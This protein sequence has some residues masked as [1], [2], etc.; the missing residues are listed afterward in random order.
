MKQFFA[1]FLFFVFFSSAIAQMTVDSSATGLQLAQYLAG[2]GVNISN[3][4]M[5]CP[6]GAFA[7][8]DG[9]SAT[10]LGIN[11]GVALT[12]GTALALPQQSTF[13]A[14]AGSSTIGDADLDAIL[15]TYPTPTSSEDACVLEFD[16]QVNGDS[17]NFNYV[18]GSEEY[19]N[20]TCS[21]F[22]DI[23]AFLISGPNPQGGNYSKQNI[24]LIPGTNLPVSIN[25]VNSGQPSGANDPANCVSLAYS[26][27]YNNAP[28]IVYDG[29]TSV[30]AASIAT[31][32]CQTYRLKLAIAD[33]GDAS[34]DSGV[35]LEAYSFTAA[36]I[37]ISPGTNGNPLFVNAVEGCSPSGFVLSIDNVLSDSFAISYSIGGTAIEGGDYPVIPKS[38]TLAPG[39]V[40][41]IVDINPIFDGVNEGLES[42]V[43]YLL[44]SCTNLPYDSAIIFIQDSVTAAAITP[45]DTVCFGEKTQLIAGGGLSYLWGPASTLSATNVYNP[46]A[47]PSVTTTYNVTVTVGPCSDD[48]S[49]VITVIDPLFSI[50]AGLDDTLCLN[51][52]ATVPLQV[53]GNQLPYSFDWSSGIYLSDSAIQNPVT[54]PKSSVTYEVIVTGANGCTQRDTINYVV[55]GVG[56]KVIIDTDRNFVCSGDTVQL[57]ANIYPLTCGLNI[58]PCTGTF[59]I[60]DVGDGN[61]PFGN[62]P[63]GNFS[64]AQRTQI[65]Y[66]AS[67]LNAAGI[68]SVTI[69]D[70]VFD[71]STQGTL[72]PFDNFTVKIGCTDA[73]ELT[74]FQ[75]NLSTVYSNSYQLNG[76]G[77]NTI[78]LDNAYDWDG[79]SNLVIEICYEVFGAV[80]FD[81]VVSNTQTYPCFYQAT[82]FNEPACSAQFGFSSQTRPNLR[83]IYCQNAPKTY[84]FN[85]VPADNLILPNVL[86]PKAVINNNVTYILNVKDSVCSG[87][88][89]INL[90]L[91]NYGVFA[92]NDTVTCSDDGIQLNAVLVGDVPLVLINCGV[93]N[94]PCTLPNTHTLTGNLN[95]FSFVT[96]F[97][98]G[99]NE[100]LRHQY[101]YRASDLAAAGVEPGTIT[102]I[103]FNVNNKLSLGGFQNFSIKMTCSALAEFEFSPLDWEPTQTVYSTS[104]LN[105]VQGWNEFT[106]AS[107]FDWDGNS[108]IIVEVCWDNPDG[109]TTVNS[110]AIETINTSYV[111]S[112]SGGAIAEVGCNLPIFVSFANFEL[113][114]TRFKSCSAPL[115]TPHYTWSP[116]TD[117]SNPNISNPIV[118]PTQATTYTVLADFPG[119]CVVADTIVV[120]KGS[121]DAFVLFNDTVILEGATIQ[122]FADVVNAIGATTYQWAP[123]TYLDNSN[124]QNPS[125]TPAE[126]ILY[127]VTAYNQGC[128]DT[129]SVFVR[130]RLPD[131]QYAIPNAF[132]PNSDGKNDVFLPFLPPNSSIVLKEMRVYNRWGAMVYNGVAGWDGMFNGKPQPA[133]TFVYY[134][135]MEQPSKVTETKQGSVT[136]IR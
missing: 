2:G 124:I 56:P 18:F 108:N 120:D 75:A 102:S 45:D 87:S 19:P 44:N 100:D 22:T 112:F 93:N 26:N 122:L 76:M 125:T 78:T 39:Q 29:H 41:T 27:F 55:K 86:N 37:T 88:G 31:V 57:A 58:D 130:L 30:F 118:K 127:V 67:E 107:N 9:A 131:G 28:T 106:L 132:T 114:V 68:G 73:Q 134:I 63:F 95:P 136:L 81:E 6:S 121:L 5:N 71:I 98:G 82:P 115:V 79:V 14:S 54:T 74:A 62:S 42:V 101:L 32:P 111:S 84:S 43:L 35:M 17:L 34:F 70:V 77:P 64:S 7:K 105:T 104:V 94:T 53:N 1:S 8:F 46:V 117:L 10:S 11:E 48:A 103:G 38:V 20:Y 80:D 135:V 85:W 109:T 92:G 12:T 128:V 90:S 3:L 60:G 126:D 21:Q 133:G 89:V 59:G 36:N 24:A 61:A 47:T 91:A 15:A 13:F 97:D 116:I 96:P 83:L 123:V 65:L 25:T 113:P 50:N 66:R 52:A 72:I 23:F 4:T 16:I 51:E 49:V 110:D 33:A 129:A 99:F 119:G 69:S 40:T